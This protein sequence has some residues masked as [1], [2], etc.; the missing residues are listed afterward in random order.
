MNAMAPL[1]QTHFCGCVCVC[2]CDCDCVSHCSPST[3]P[4]A[5]MRSG[6]SW[7]SQTLTSRQT[8]SPNSPTFVQQLSPCVCVCLWLS[9]I[10]GLL[11]A[12]WLAILFFFLLLVYTCVCFSRAA[13]NARLR[14][15]MGSVPREKHTHRHK[16]QLWGRG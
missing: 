9:N 2:A 8:P 5:W 6:R 4:C 16:H 14:H 7:H 15:V 3:F 12:D 1:L 13:A 11:L 10:H